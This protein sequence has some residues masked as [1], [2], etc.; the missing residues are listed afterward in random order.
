M[1][2]S[3]KENKHSFAS[4]LMIIVLFGSLAVLA[5]V[6]VHIFETVRNA[7]QDSIQRWLGQ[8]VDQWIMMRIFDVLELANHEAKESLASTAISGNA[9]IDGWLMQRTYA[10]LVGL[11]VV[12]YR[13]GVLLMWCAF[14]IPVI[15][16]TVV[17]GHF[18]REI[19][20]TSFTSQS[21]V[22]HKSGLDLFKTAI[23][24]LVAWVF[25]PWHITM[26]AAPIGVF[27]TGVSA[28][29]WISNAPKRI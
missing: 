4:V 15:F 6:P 26:L 2:T 9:K 23:A 19:R 1:A 24:L 21:P 28:W 16:A 25:M 7:E 5:L 10:A 20:K 12:L 8:E 17:D 22:L 11:H 27:T 18:L 14:G 29:L 13:S 3:P